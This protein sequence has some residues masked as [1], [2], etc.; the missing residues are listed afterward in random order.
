MPS[1]QP[2]Q[3]A[4]HGGALVGDP[5]CGAGFW[6]SK[7]HW[8]IPTLVLT[9]TVKRWAISSLVPP[10]GTGLGRQCTAILPVQIPTLSATEADKDGPPGYLWFC[11]S[12]LCHRGPG[13]GVLPAARVVQTTIGLAGELATA[14]PFDTFHLSG[15]AS[16]LVLIGPRLERAVFHGPDAL[17]VVDN[18]V[19]AIE[20][21]HKDSP[22]LQ[23]GWRN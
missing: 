5:G 4:R 9:Q 6:A 13:D 14:R 17:I 18:L 8:Q 21:L 15:A 7:F 16:N 2:P 10:S 12:R 11:G 1:L 23:V 3:Q 19:A 20:G 22:V